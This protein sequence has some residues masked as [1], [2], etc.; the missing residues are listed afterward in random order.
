MQEA[1]FVGNRQSKRLAILAVGCLVFIFILA[2]FP[3]WKSLVLFWASSDD[4]SHGFLIV[5][6]AFYIMWKKRQKLII[7][8]VQ[9]SWWGLFILILSLMAYVGARYAEILTIAS[10]SMIFA[11]AG[12]VI[13]LFGF[14]IF[15]EISFPLFLLIFMIPIPSQIYTTLT[16][17]LQLF[18]SMVSTGVGDLIGIPVYRE[19]NVIHLPDRTF[20]VVRAC[21]GL[22]SMVALM[23]LSAVFGYFTLQKMSLRTV[24]F[25]TGMP[26]AVCVNIIRVTVMIIVFHYL[27]IDLSAGSMHTIFG[28][29]IYLLALLI[30][31]TMMK[32]LSRWE[33]SALEIS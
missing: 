21:S 33:K 10:I 19:G 16:I 18:V 14:R 8:P 22:R 2:Y 24:L 6:I 17:P 29:L 27:D 5:P 13:F 31:F 23:T 28:V 11:L 7:V 9:H 12:T 26:A 32:V 3:V 30:I 20:Q 1:Q 4:Y 25:F 15:K